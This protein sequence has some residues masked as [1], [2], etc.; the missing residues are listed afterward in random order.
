MIVMIPVV[1]IITFFGYVYYNVSGGGVNSKQ[2]RERY[3]K[4]NRGSEGNNTW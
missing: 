3:K 4:W 1:A 2:R